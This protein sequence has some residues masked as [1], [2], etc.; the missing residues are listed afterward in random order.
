MS[1]FIIALVTFLA[2]LHSV[3]IQMSGQIVSLQ[4]CKVTLV[5]F[6][7]LFSSVFFKCVLKWHDQEDAKSHKLHLFDF[8]PL[9]FFKGLLKLPAREKAYSHWLHFLAF[10]HSTVVDCVFADESSCE[11]HLVDVSNAL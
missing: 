11:K 10:L 8:S 3:S 5:T 9:Y 2:F 6:V 7:W 1:L 4:V